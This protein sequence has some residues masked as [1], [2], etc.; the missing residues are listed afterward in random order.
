LSEARPDAS[1]FRDD[2][3]ILR[4]LFEE[5]RPRYPSKLFLR[6]ALD[7]DIGVVGIDAGAGGADQGHGIGLRLV[8]TS[9]NF[10][11]EWTSSSADLHGEWSNQ[12]F[13]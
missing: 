12:R 6:H 2:I 10:C 7:R 13:P 11:S 9:T 8:G 1:A 5:A 3:R 4:L